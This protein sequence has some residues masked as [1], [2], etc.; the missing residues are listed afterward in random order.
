MGDR[1]QVFV[2]RFG[3]ED[4]VYLY[5]HWGATTLPQDVEKAIAKRWRWNDP[6]YLA[7]IIFDVMTEDSHGEETGYGIGIQEAGDIWRLITVDCKA[8]TIR[9]RDEDKEVFMGSFEAV[10]SQEV[11][12]KWA[13]AVA[14][15]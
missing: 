6:D 9:V 11:L 8:Q 7:R 4:G 12:S 10:A 15:Q 2:K 3:G 1:G 5:T 13:V 14:Q